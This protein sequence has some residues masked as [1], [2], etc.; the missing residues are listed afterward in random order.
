M[1]HSGFEELVPIQK[2]SKYKPLIFG[3]L[4]EYLGPNIDCYFDFVTELQKWLVFPMVIG[5]LTVAINYYFEY[6]A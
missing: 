4:K 2:V 5:L 3:S 1:K 6:T